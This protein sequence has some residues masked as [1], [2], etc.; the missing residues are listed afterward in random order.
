MSEHEK[1]LA[2]DDEALVRDTRQDC[3]TAKEAPSA[4]TLAQKIKMHL[5]AALIYTRYLAPAVFGILLFGLSFFDWVYFFMGGDPLKMSLFAFYKQTIT[6]S[7]RYV[8]G[9]TT[10]AMNGFYGLMAAAAALCLVFYV[11]ALFLSGLSA[12]TAVRAFR[13]GHES[14]ESNRA[15]VAFKVAYPNR[16]CLLLSNALY[17][18]PTL[19]PEIFSAVGRLFLSI[20]GSGT[21]FVTVN[22][23]FIITIVFTALMLA[24]SLGIKRYEYRKKMNMFLF[25]LPEEEEE[26]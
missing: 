17:L 7:L 18:V 2:L 22:V 9:T 5:P 16:I 21:V 13:A 3:A 24:L 4:F 15:K 14:E 10:A 8:G 1:D 25:W 6:S 23:F 11:L 19:F 20:S 12:V 26:K